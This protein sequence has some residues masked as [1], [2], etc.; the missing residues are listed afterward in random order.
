M[1]VSRHALRGIGWAAVLGVCFVLLFALALRVNAL[2]SEVRLTERKIL[3][4]KRETLYL[5]T[6][7]ETRANQQQLAQ[8]NAVEFGYVA[9]GAGQ[10]LE[11]ERALA[12][13]GKA[14]GPGA[15]API[16]V[17]AAVARP[18][19]VMPTMVSPLTG[20]P[21][22]ED[23]DVA[24]AP[25]DHAAAAAKLGERLGKVE[26]DTPAKADSAKPDT[27]K[28]SATKEARP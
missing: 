6:E 9:P 14:A 5:E 18:P 16:R 24:A 4:L 19:G 22:G 25:V 28:P 1:I 3:A 7:F 11:N 15:P 27:A 17:A 23:D 26:H 10:Y 12:S 8:W 13:L 21:L 2:K 20:K